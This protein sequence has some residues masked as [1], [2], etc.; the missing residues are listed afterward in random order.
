[1][2]LVLLVFLYDIIVPVILP[3][4]PPPPTGRANVDLG[5]PLGLEGVGYTGIGETQPL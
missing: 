1:M 5:C 3:L 2:I 4:D